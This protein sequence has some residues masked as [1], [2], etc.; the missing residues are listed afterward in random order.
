MYK[1]REGRV[2]GMLAM[3]ELKSQWLQHRK[4][5]GKRGRVGAGGLAPSCQRRFFLGWGFWVACWP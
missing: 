3:E 2:T 5:V 1:L 4:Q